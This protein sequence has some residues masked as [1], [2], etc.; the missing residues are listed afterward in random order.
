[1]WK[2]KPGLSRAEARVYGWE[3]KTVDTRTGDPE[4]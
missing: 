4:R 1:M 2:A 3:V